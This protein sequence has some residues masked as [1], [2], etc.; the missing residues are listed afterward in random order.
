[1]SASLASALTPE[2]IEAALDAAGIGVWEMDWTGRRFSCSSRCKHLFGLPAEAAVSLDD[3]LGAA[4]PEDRPVL[5]QQLQQALDPQGNG[6]LSVEHRVLL[7][8]DE[9]R[10]VRTTG[11]AVFDEARTQPV[12]FQGITKD[13]TDTQAGA[14]LQEAQR[15]ELE[16]LAESIPG[17]LWMARPSGAVTYFNQRWMEYTGQTL[18]QALDR[19]WES[20]VHPADLPRCLERWNTA[21]ATGSLYEVEYRLRR[22]DGQYRWY[23][24]RALP[25]RDAAG[26]IVKWFGTCTDIHDQ[27][28]TEEALRRHEEELERAYQDLEAKITFRTLALE[29]EVSA[30]RRRVAQLPGADAPV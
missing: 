16:Y 23:V 13:I 28:Q 11:L 3:V 8:G 29:D 27:K 22:Q 12:R 9:V 30:L 26:Q 24:G 10:W 17:I 18:E 20:V 19:G 4:H 15:R 6:R 1:M 5:E 7:P 21:L 2:R 25:Y 14:R